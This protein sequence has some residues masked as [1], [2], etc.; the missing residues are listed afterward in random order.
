MATETRHDAADVEALRRE[1]ESIRWWHTIDLG[2]G[3][4]TPGEGGSPALLERMHMPADL[5][6]KSV[7]D[8]GTFDGFFAFE[9]ERRGAER[10]VAVDHRVPPGFRIAHRALGSGVEF[11]E[12]D[13][14]TL[15]REE[16]GVFDVVFFLGV[17]YHLPDPMGALERVREVTGELMICETEGALSWLEEPAVQFVGSEAALRDSALNWWYPNMPALVAMTQAAGFRDVR[18]MSGP[19]AAPRT[20]A[21]KVMRKLRKRHYA[22]FSPRLVVHARP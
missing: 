9:A 22:S 19:P 15:S 8:I 1:V 2:N 16:L 3:V 10:V 5:T 21:G 14:M 6:G 11:R 12:A 7:L 4:V 18:P 13:V 17:I 20:L